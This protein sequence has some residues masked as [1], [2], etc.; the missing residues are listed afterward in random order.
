M[1]GDN[2]GPYYNNDN[3]SNSPQKY[4]DRPIKSNRRGSD[5]QQNMGYNNNNYN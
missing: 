4:D 3:S 1:R 2:N 5:Y